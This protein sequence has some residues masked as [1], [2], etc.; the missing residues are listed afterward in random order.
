MNYNYDYG[1]YMVGN[2]NYPTEY[3]YS[4]MNYKGNKANV[5]FMNSDKS[6][7]NNDNSTGKKQ[8]IVDPYIGLIR[9][10][11]FNNLYDPYKDYTPVDIVVTN[12]RESLL[13]QIQMYNFATVDLNLYLDLHPNDM[14]VFNKFR[15]YTN[16]YKRY[17]NEFEKTYRPLCL[18]SINKD[19]YEYY[20]NP[21]PWDNDAG[22]YYV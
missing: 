8:I 21:W 13:G 10:N 19:S 20:K 14:A 1:N 12:E 18:S 15:E 3:G 5:T 9:G 4:N 2:N 11:L 6:T 16:E 22:V 7:I 17:L